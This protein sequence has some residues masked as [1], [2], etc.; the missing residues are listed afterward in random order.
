MRKKSLIEPVPELDVTV[1]A[2]EL[3]DALQR[4]GHAIG[5][6]SS[7]PAL[8]HVLL[9]VSGDTLTVVT[10]DLELYCEIKLESEVRVDGAIVVPF[11]VFKDMLRNVTGDVVLSTLGDTLHITTSRGTATVIC[12]PAGEFPN[13][14]VLAPSQE[15]HVKGL[16]AAL[17]QVT[18]IAA[19]DTERP[20]IAA[21]AM[22]L[23]RF[24]A[25]DTHRLVIVQHPIGVDDWQQILIPCET[26]EKLPKI[27]ACK[28]DADI[29]VASRNADQIRFAVGNTIVYSRLVD[30]HA[31]DYDKVV[32][33]ETTGSIE[34]NPAQL[35]DAVDWVWPVAV[36]YS[37]RMVCKIAN[38]KIALHSSAGVIGEADAAC[39]VESAG[40][41]SDFEIAL[42]CKYLREGLALFTGYSA[43]KI[44][45]NGQVDPVM[46]TSDELPEVTYVVMPM[47]IG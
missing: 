27:L 3:K 14:P 17:G 33:S 28:P 11:Q 1:L 47:Q 31:P 21:V 26:C 32:P 6:R 34:V 45:G 41:W 29:A 15:T 46:I 2:F 43:V 22:G 24:I 9:R 30:G 23:D 37:N 39:P 42:S 5:P 16:L 35:I 8:M 10:T 38:D 36:E 20:V 44:A 12:L 40:K 19:R 4:A 13:L 25:T 7:L 18:P